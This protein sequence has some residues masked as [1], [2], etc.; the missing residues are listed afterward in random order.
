[1]YSTLHT[2]RKKS[3][4]PSCFVP[5]T[6]RLVLWCISDSVQMLLVWLDFAFLKRLVLQHN[7]DVR[8]SL[9][10]NVSRRHTQTWLPIVSARGELRVRELSGATL[11]NKSIHIVFTNGTLISIIRISVF[12]EICLLLLSDH[13]FPPKWPTSYYIMHR[14]HKQK[15][16]C[17]WEQ[18]VCRSCFQNKQAPLSQRQYSSVLLLVWR[19]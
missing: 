13:P 16:C 12:L 4:A 18:Q 11:R 3:D 14:D 15:L 5:A 8:F 10:W 19:L 17:L 1:M 9:V 6:K 7:W 2:A